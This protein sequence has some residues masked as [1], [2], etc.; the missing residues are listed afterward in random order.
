[1]CIRD[2]ALQEVL[3]MVHGSAS[4]VEQPIPADFVK[5]VAARESRI[6]N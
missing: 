4:R 3:L 5:A 2:R 6:E 1:M